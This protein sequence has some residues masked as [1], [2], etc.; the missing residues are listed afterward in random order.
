MEGGSNPLIYK[1]QL[2]GRYNSPN[3]PAPTTWF[4]GSNLKEAATPCILWL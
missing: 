3:F 1:I 2:E 4:I